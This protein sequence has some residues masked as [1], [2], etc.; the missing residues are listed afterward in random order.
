MLI[1]VISRYCMSW[2]S[3]WIMWNKC[4][5]MFS[6]QET[7]LNSQNQLGKKIW[8]KTFSLKI[9]WQTW[10]VLLEPNP[11]ITSLE[12]FQNCLFCSIH[13]FMLMK[14]L[15]SWNNACDM[16]W[17]MHNMLHLYFYLYMF[18]IFYYT[19]KQHVKTRPHFF[20]G[21]KY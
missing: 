6:L 9:L 8:W 12:I 15:F 1:E 5:V 3:V 17:G 21:I 13:C 14:L 20:Q 2:K 4:H 16:W 18:H 7:M 11:L 19:L 10:K